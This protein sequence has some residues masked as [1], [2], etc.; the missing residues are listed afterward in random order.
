[1][2]RRKMKRLYLVEATSEKVK[3]MSLE[4]VKL[5]IQN[6]KSMYESYDYLW[7]MVE[8]SER[9]DKIEYDLTDGTHDHFLSIPRLQEIQLSLSKREEE[10]KTIKQLESKQ[11]E[12]E[13]KALYNSVD[14]KNLVQFSRP[15]HFL[16]WYHT[17]DQMDKS[18]P[19]GFDI[20]PA[21]IVVHMLKGSVAG[22]AVHER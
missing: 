13:N 16:A 19:G 22:D 11:K 14:Q 3:T 20:V 9:I 4:Q 8:D 7:S 17:V 15:E 12:R 1:M 10:L 6:A 5:Y 2:H 18:I 21:N